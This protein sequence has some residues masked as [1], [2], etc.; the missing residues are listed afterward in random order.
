MIKMKSKEKII[1]LQNWFNKNNIQ[2]YIAKTNSIY[3]ENKNYEVIKIS[4]HQL[5][6]NIS[7]PYSKKKNLLRF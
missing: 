5:I 7:N 6:E 3:I 1:E 4:N 2:Y